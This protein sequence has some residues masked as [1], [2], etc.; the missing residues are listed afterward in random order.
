[1]SGRYK[2][3]IRSKL[4]F[5]YYGSYNNGR[6]TLAFSS[7]KAVNTNGPKNNTLNANITIIYNSIFTTIPVTLN[8]NNANLHYMLVGENVSGTINNSKKLTLHFNND[9][10]GLSN[11]ITFKNNIDYLVNED[12]ILSPLVP[13]I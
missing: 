7:I 1:M 8:W 13:P 10:G 6:V 2:Q 4:K 3:G 9:V 11:S 5:Y 12:L